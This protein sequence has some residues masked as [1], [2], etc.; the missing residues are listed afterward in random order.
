M[1]LNNTYSSV[2]NPSYQG[3]NKQHLK[4]T[5]QNPLLA[6]P[7]VSDLMT[8]FITARFISLLSVPHGREARVTSVESPLSVPDGREASVNTV[9][10]SPLSEPYGREASV[11]TVE[12]SPLSVPHGREASVIAVKKSPLSVPYGREARLNTVE[13]SHILVQTI[14]PKHHQEVSVIAAAQYAIKNKNKKTCKNNKT[15]HVQK[16]KKNIKVDENFHTPNSVKKIKSKK[17]K[18]I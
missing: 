13:R 2:T 14:L 16:R 11:I 15:R 8:N 17:S 4:K 10:K 5:S 7:E 1:I 6:C 12:K 18:N 9:K 3:G